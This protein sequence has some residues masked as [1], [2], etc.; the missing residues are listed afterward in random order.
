MAS[1]NADRKE[2]QQKCESVQKNLQLSENKILTLTQKLESAETS[3]EN[4]KKELAQMK[5]DNIL[6]RQALEEKLEETRKK[7][8]ELSDE[9]LQTKINSEKSIALSSQQNEFF[10]KKVQELEKSLEQST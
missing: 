4:K 7:Y 8:Q 5:Q 9:H 6:E 3:Y 2:L 10:Q 1:Y